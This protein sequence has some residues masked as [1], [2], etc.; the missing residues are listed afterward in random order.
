MHRNPVKQGGSAHRRVAQQ[1]R[2]SDRFYLLE[3]A[4]PPA[5]ERGMAEGFVSESGGVA[6][7]L[8]AF[9]VPAPSQRTRR[10]YPE[11]SQ[12][13]RGALPARI[14]SLGRLPVIV[15][16]PNSL[17]RYFENKLAIKND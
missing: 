9:V 15:R 5:G 7:Q 11:R 2:S 8:K 1:R 13:E 3:D 6:S 12:W 16:S 10:A 14:K 17:Y 4:G